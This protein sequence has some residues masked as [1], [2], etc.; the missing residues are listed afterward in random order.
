MQAK[1]SQWKRKKKIQ[2]PILNESN[3]DG[4]NWKKKNLM[5]KDET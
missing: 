2:S 3:L 1:L 5:L 4:W